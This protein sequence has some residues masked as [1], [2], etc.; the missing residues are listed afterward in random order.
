MASL[1]V[2]FNCLGPLRDAGQLTVAELER[3]ARM[4]TNL[5]GMRRWGYIT[6]DGV[7]RVRRGSG[8]RPRPKRS[9]LLALTARGEVAEAV[10]RGLP[11]AIGARW[12]ERFCPAAIERLRGELVVIARRSDVALPDS[13]RSER[14]TRETPQ[15]GP[16]ALSESSSTAAELASFMAAASASASP[17]NLTKWRSR[18]ACAAIDRLASERAAAA[19]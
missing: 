6:I 4:A 2:W 16:D 17:T 12:R 14:A 11:T 19:R 5:D 8:S 15:T 13:C 9:S 3:T 10:W 7:G 1:A 18:R